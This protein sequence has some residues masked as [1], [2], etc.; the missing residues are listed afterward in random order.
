MNS[1]WY[2][3]HEHH[4]QLAIQAIGH[5]LSWKDVQLKI[6]RASDED[7]Y[8]Q[9]LDS[10]D[11]DVKLSCV[12]ALANLHHEV[13]SSPSF[14]SSGLSSSA[15]VPVSRW[16]HWAQTMQMSTPS[17]IRATIFCRSLPKMRLAREST[18]GNEQR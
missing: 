11:V 4:Q 16:L 6:A 18:A 17:T 12:W 10:N 2:G 8:S 5:V 9:L 7:I 1:C 13:P 14:S 15:S 3:E